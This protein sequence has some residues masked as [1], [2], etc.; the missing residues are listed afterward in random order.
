MMWEGLFHSIVSFNSTTSTME[1][2]FAA[3][4]SETVT[5]ELQAQLNAAIANIPPAHRLH[6]SRDEVFE[7]KEAAFIRLQDWAFINGFA[8]VKESSKTKAGQVNRVYLDCV[9][10]KKATKNSRKLDEVARKRHQTKTQASHCLF[11]LVIY[12]DESIGW[13]VRPKCLEHN[14]APS[15]DPFQYHQH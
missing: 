1:P 15:P 10:H 8:I 12:H 7:S 2:T 6:P 5:A 14:H 11:S 9:H 4:T 13:G 3:S